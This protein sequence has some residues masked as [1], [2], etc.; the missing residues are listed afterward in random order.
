MLA[1][2]GDVDDFRDDVATFAGVVPEVFP[3]WDRL[4]Q[5]SSPGDEVFG[6]RLR[7]LKRLGGEE[8][9]RFVVAPMQALLQPVPTAELLARTSRTVRVGDTI[10]V[11]ELAAWL[12]E[13]GMSRVEVVEVAGEFSMRGGIVD[14]FS[15]DEAEPVRIEFFGDEV[16]S[17]RP[18]DPETQRS[19][20][21]WESVTLTA[22]PPL[23][24]DD[25]ANQRPPA[26]A[27]PEGTWVALVEPNDLREEGR[28]Y[29]GR[30]GDPRGLYS[31]ESTFARLVKHPSITL[32]TLAASS[33]E[34]TCH[35]RIESV[36]RFSG[37][38]AKVKAELE[39]ASAG[40]RVL[41]ACHNA[42]EV[43]RLG[44]V[45]AD[46]AIAQSGRL[47][48][49]IGRVRSGFH[50][51]DAQTLVIGDHELFAR[52]DVRRPTN[53]RRVREPGDRQLPRPQRGRPGRPRQ[54][55]DRP[56]PRPATGRQ[57]GRARRGDLAPG[58]RRG[59]E[60][61]TSRSPRSTWSRS[62][63]AAARP[64]PGSRRSAR[65]AGRSGSRGWPRRS[66]TSP[67]S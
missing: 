45:F 34:A 36:E 7:V 60:A 15:P 50:M 31:V 9:P 52:A 23:A 24:G 2:V 57:G 54:P 39:S 41:I 28:H 48:R 66:S 51:I 16:E 40:D 43:E 32:S 59:D 38:L 62:T 46:T 26:D 55:R 5:E 47:H 27:F 21:R 64:S 42:A 11:E 49:T 12:V 20:G 56:L 33:L 58:V 17:I 53:R 44:E 19:L 61:V 13:R 35:L 63:S 30:S 65:R 22:T 6:R 29:L 1:H 18:F 8:P 10:A 3:A 4:P 14:I 67:P 25:L 37:E